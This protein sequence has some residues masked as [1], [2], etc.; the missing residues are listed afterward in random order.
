MSVLLQ[1]RWK[2]LAPIFDVAIVALA[3][4]LLMTPV[5][6]RGEDIRDCTWNYN[7]Q[8]VDRVIAACRR[9]ADRRRARAQRRPG[10]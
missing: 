7:I 1:Q 8:D 2:S 10:E 3:V 6:A 9:L 5:P 4:A